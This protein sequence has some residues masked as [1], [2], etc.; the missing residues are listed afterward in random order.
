MTQHLID[1]LGPTALPFEICSAEGPLLWDAVAVPTGISMGGMPS[2]CSVKAIPVGLQRWPNRRGSSVS[3]PPW[4]PLLYEV[5]R[6]QS[7]VASRAWIK[8][9]SSTAERNRTKQH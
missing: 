1:N 8:F 4:D 9:S 6:P 3:S 7:C 5:E 2:H